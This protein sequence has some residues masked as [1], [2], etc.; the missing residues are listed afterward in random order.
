MPASRK[1]TID[2]QKANQPY[3]PFAR[4]TD[5]NRLNSVMLLAHLVT[6]KYADHQPLYRQIR[7]FGREGSWLHPRPPKKSPPFACNSCPFTTV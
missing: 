2:F 4:R 6:G 5:E 1:Y 7:I 3:L